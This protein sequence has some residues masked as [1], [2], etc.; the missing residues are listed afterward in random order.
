MLTPYVYGVMSTAALIILLADCGVF[1]RWSRRKTR[2]IQRLRV[3]GFRLDRRL[4]SLHH[5][6][7]D[8][9]TT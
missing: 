9:G 6:D 2:R 3:H 5:I 4:D 8:Q 7:G 1:D